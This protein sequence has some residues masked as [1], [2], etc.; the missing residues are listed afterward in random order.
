MNPNIRTI[1]PQPLTVE[2]FA[3]FGEAIL[4]PVKD[5]SLTKA[6]DHWECWFGVGDLTPGTST[7]GIVTTRWTDKPIDVM[8]AHSAREL[9]MPIDKP[10][11]QAVAPNADMDDIDTKP[12]L[13]EVR[14]F[15]IEPG[16]AIIMDAGSWHYAAVPFEGE[17]IYYFVTNRESKDPGGTPNRWIE[18]GNNQAYVLQ[19]S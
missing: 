14:A 16:Q 2:D 12:V 18:F 11:V 5:E 19:R 1:V 9:L 6:A 3:P 4:R 10:I 13:D 8:E 17:A 7:L 15:I